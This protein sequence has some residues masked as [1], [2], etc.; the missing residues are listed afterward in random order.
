MEYCEFAIYRKLV[1]VSIVSEDWLWA[2]AIV[3]WEGHMLCMMW[4]S[5]LHPQYAIWPPAPQ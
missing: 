1:Q 2:L 3:Q 5:G 4:A